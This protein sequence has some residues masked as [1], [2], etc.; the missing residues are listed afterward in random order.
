MGHGNTFNCSRLSSHAFHIDPAH[1]NIPYYGTDCSGSLAYL[2][3]TLSI[4][5][6]ANDNEE[7]L[8]PIHTDGDGHCLVYAISRALIGREL[9]WHALR[10]NLR[11][12]FLEKL[13]IYKM[14]FE[15][16]IHPLEWQ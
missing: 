11:C 1:L 5:K 3:E 14:H 6:A 16:F 9:F 2:S 7:I 13:E 8:V 4:I 10:K 15:D 12:H